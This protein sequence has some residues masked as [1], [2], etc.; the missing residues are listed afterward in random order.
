VVPKVGGSS[1]L[2]H[3]TPEQ[4]VRTSLLPS[5]RAPDGAL[6]TLC[7]RAASP[8][9][10]SLGVHGDGDVGVAEALADD[11]GRHAGSE[12][13]GRVAVSDIMQPNL[14]EPAARV[15]CSNHRESR[16]G[17]SGRPSGQVNT[18]PESSQRG[19]TAS[20]SSSCQRRWSRGAAT[21]AGSSAGE[22]R[23]LAVFGSETRT[24]WL[25]TT[26]G[27]RG[28][29]RPASK[30]T[31]IQ[32]S[33]AASPCACRWWPAATSGVQPVVSDVVEEGAELLQPQIV[34]WLAGATHR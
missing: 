31:S 33:P 3:P 4:R 32:R 2:G 9:G 34:T 5:D 11:L 13:C 8:G 10:S 14:G 18:S 12:C 1:P 25:T 19:P 21:V 26:R 24:S 23:P 6:S 30:S 27:R 22:R 7:Q 16:S 17:C 29:T 15:C 28:E 20:R